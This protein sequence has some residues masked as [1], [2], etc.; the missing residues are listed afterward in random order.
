MIDITEMLKN[1]KRRTGYIIINRP[2][3]LFYE[4]IGSTKY[5]SF[6]SD[7]PK[8][9]FDNVLS[10]KIKDGWMRI[11]CIDEV[12]RDLLEADLKDCRKRTKIK[13]VGNVIKLTKNTIGPGSD[14]KGPPPNCGSNVHK[15]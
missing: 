7:D 4:E 5:Q 10:V 3:I 13:P 15:Q 9:T 6:D 14:V 8:D 11:C 12:E 1:R 2:I